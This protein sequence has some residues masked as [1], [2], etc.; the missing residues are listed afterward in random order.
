[1]KRMKKLWK[2]LNSRPREVQTYHQWL[3]WRGWDN[4]FDLFCIR[5]EWD[6]PHAYSIRF[7]FLGLGLR[8]MFV[9][10]S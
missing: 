8:I 5:L 6:S 3:F 1:M 2:I 10:R 7:L 4:D 9:Y